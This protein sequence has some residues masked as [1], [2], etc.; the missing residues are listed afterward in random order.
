M[1]Q[2]EQNT[3]AADNLIRQ[4]MQESNLRKAYMLIDAA[5]RLD[6]TVSTD[7]YKESITNK[8][9]SAEYKKRIQLGTIG[10]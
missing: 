9:I 4:A 8:W 6:D 1:T 2:H 3:L 5:Y 7:C 10:A